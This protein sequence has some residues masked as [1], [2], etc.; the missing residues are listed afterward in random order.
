MIKIFFCLWII[1]GYFVVRAAHKRSSVPDVLTG[2]L[3]MVLWPFVLFIFDT[4]DLVDKIWG[5]SEK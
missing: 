5:K 1:I 3:A 4:H 2:I